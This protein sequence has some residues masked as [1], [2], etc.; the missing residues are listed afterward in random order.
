[1]FYA[2]ESIGPNNRWYVMLTYESQYWAEV[3][4]ERLGW[5]NNPAYRIKLYR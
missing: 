5:K 2:I 3:A 4:L 1:M